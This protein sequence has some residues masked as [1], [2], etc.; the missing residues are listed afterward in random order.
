L[1]SVFNLSF[2][3]ANV[4]IKD[5]NNIEQIWINKYTTNNNYCLVGKNNDVKSMV[6]PIDVIK[7]VSIMSNCSVNTEFRKYSI[8]DESYLAPEGEPIEDYIREEYSTIKGYTGGVEI[9]TF[10]NSQA[11]SLN[12]DKIEIEKWKN[13]EISVSEKCIKLNITNSL[14]DY[15]LE[16]SSFYNMWKNI[17]L[18]D[19]LY[20]IQYIKNCILKYININNKI[21]FELRR[22]KNKTKTLKCSNKYYKNF[23]EYTNF[24]NELKYEDD[25]YYMYVYVDEFYTYYPKITIML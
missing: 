8:I 14:I 25:K 6:F 7:N 10:L 23:I 11:L 4:Y 24:K 13:T 20:K 18:K 19:N 5:T 17:K 21:K 22:S 3:G 12:L 2:D 9:K 16:Q 15:I 1:E